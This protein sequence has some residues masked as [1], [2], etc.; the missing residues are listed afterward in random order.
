MPISFT[1]AV[2]AA[3]TW[4][5][6]CID[7]IGVGSDNQMYRQSWTPQGRQAGWDLL[8]G[9]FVSN[10]TLTAWGADRLDAFCLDK[11]SLKSMHSSWD[12][13]KWEGEWTAINDQSF[14]QPPA[15]DA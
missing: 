10:P 12:G 5:S 3:A 15:V 14:G 11:S 8:G 13:S 1:T 2:I 6:N 4:A 9:N 7:L